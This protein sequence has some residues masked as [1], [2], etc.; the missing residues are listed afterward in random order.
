MDVLERLNRT[1]GTWYEGLFGAGADER[2]LRPRDILRRI[3]VT[4]EDQRRE[5]LDGQ[6]YVPNHYTL[7][8]AVRDDDE[9]HYLRTFFDAD[10]LAAAVRRAMDQHGYKTRGGLRFQIEEMDAAS[11][12]AAGDGRVRIRCRFDA[13]I[14]DRA[15]PSEAA[16][17]PDDAA[18]AGE[19]GTVPAAIALGSLT[20]RGP[21]GAGEAYPLTPRGARIG[22]SR[23]AGNDVVLADDVMVSKRHARI[24]ADNGRFVLQD[25]GSTNGTFV[26]GAPL[27]PGEIH[28]LRSGDE[29]RV[30]ETCWCSARGAPPPSRRRACPP[31]PRPR[32]PFR[33]R[34]PRAGRRPGSWPRTGKRFRWRRR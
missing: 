34:S 22:R 1:F 19:P 18:D 4:M 26:N 14:P 6:V 32:P 25:V 7:A 20:V 24:A 30:G 21:H 15:V 11:D 17:L 5:G 28:L 2:E 23:Q 33:R 31:R 3:L 27:P 13:T 9:R 16:A 12:G 8:V 29:I 10:E